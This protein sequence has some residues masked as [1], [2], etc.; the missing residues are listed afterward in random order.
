MIKCKK[1]REA[2]PFELSTSEYDNTKAYT[3]LDEYVMVEHGCLFDQIKNELPW[4]GTHKN[5]YYWV[6]LVNGFVVG[7]NENPA[8]GWSF[9][10]LKNPYHTTMLIEDW[11]KLEKYYKEKYKNG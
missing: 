4:P 9:P 6:E 1:L 2:M 7:W 8:R 5:V 3:M 10:V 11:E